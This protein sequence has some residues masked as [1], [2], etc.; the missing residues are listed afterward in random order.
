MAV[1]TLKI[2]DRDGHILDESSGEGYTDLVYTHGYAEGDRIILETD[3]RDL[4]IHWQVDDAIGDAFVY[5]TGNVS[6][7]IPFGERRLNMSPKAFAG[8]LHY[9][10]AEVAA[11][12]EVSAYRN[13]ARNPADQGGEVSCYPHALANVETRGESVF[14]ARNAIDGLRANRYHGEWPYTSWG[15][16]QR[17][18][19]VMR[20]DFGRLVRI[21]RIV[22]Y[23][24]AD[25]PHD[26]WWEQ[27]TVRFSDGSSEVLSMEKSTRAHEF[28]IA[29]REITWLELCELIRADDPSPFPA[30][31]QIEVYGRV[32][33]H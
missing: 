1:L 12:E 17:D 18:D 6:Y 20:V 3:T 14:A 30:L 16:N 10:Y 21:D 7:E 2:L 31:S 5:L 15:I 25:F 32:Q 23:T 8:C 19:A 33:Q 24:R 13:L 29:E 26:S 4:H 28:C 27:A 11:D 22:L 9:L